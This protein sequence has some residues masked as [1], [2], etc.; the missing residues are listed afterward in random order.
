MERNFEGRLLNNCSLDQYITWAP[1]TTPLLLAVG[2]GVVEIV[3]AQ[4]VK[5]GDPSK[6][7]LT[8]G[9]DSSIYFLRMCYLFFEPVFVSDFSK[10]RQKNYFRK[11]KIFNFFENEIFWQNFEKSENLKKI[12]YFFLK[13]VFDPIFFFDRIF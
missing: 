10:F 12:S 1:G 5:P 3:P 11:I 6:S 13:I 4:H 7:L 9:I 8:P 2:H